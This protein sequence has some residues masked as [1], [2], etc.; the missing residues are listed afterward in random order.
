[1]RRRDVLLGAAA[2]AAGASLPRSALAVEA[3]AAPRLPKDFI[4]GASTSAYQIE[5]AVEADGRQP[6]I[7]DVFSH[8]PGKIATGENGDVACDH[9]HR[10]AEDVGLLAQGRFDAYRFSIA[11]PRVV[12]GGTGEV[13]AAGLDF[14]DRLVDKLLANGISPWACLYHWDLPQALQ[15]RGGW[16]SRD[17]AGWFADYALAATARLGDRVRDWILFNEPNVHAIVGHA[18]GAHAPGLT[19]FDNFLSAQHH[20]NLA[21][22]TALAALRAQRQ[23]LR[24]GT[25]FSLQPIHA[26]SDRP[27]DQAAARRFD[28][29]WNGSSLDPLFLGR[30]PEPLA[31]RFAPLVREGDLERIR[32][33]VDFLGVNYYGPSY[34][35]DAPGALLAGAD[36]G[37]LPPNTPVTAMG[38]PVDPEGLV[39]VL[40]RLRTDYGNPVVYVTENGACYDDPAAGAAGIDDAQRAAYIADHVAAAARAVAEGSPLAGYFVWSLLDNF[41]WA[42]G[43]RRRFGVVHVDFETQARVPKRS[44][45]DLVTLMDRSRG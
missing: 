9:Y 5:G 19:G 36:Y 27:A 39:Q 15:A 17:S 2:V 34:M 6:S 37:P 7:W 33:P 25:V 29:V 12:P 38:W 35:V 44:F 28:A 24:L 18:T 10:Y 42:E 43:T 23:G 11:W 4:W 20:Q 22:G 30:Y 3:A 16:T 1:M 14:Y 8:T 45:H 13:N 40:A 41:E 31:D 21:Q 26:A 32:Q